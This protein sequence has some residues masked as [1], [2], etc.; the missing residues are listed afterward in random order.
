MSSSTADIPS[1][2]DPSP[3]H[4]YLSSLL[5]KQLLVHTTD[6]RMF[7]GDFK[8]TDNVPFHPFVL[9]LRPPPYELLL[10]YCS[11]SQERNVILSHA[12]EYRH[13]TASAIEA[14]AREQA[15]SGESGENVKVG[16]TSRFMGLIVVPGPHIV[17]I[18]VEE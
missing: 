7:A 4:A 17:K 16:M 6:G 1:T 2:A 11:I 9:P 10:T 3:Q 5:N 12:Y 14:A 15:A 18:E 13:P 8:C